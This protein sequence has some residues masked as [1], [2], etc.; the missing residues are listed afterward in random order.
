MES[1]E[2]VSRESQVKGMYVKNLLDRFRELGARRFVDLFCEGLAAQRIQLRMAPFVNYKEWMKVPGIINQGKDLE[3]TA[4]NLEGIYREWFEKIDTNPDNTMGAVDE[5][6]V[7]FFR[8]YGESIPETIWVYAIAA[9]L[10]RESELETRDEKPVAA[11]VARIM[12]PTNLAAMHRNEKGPGQRSVSRRTAAEEK[13]MALCQPGHEQ[14]FINVF[15]DALEKQPT[16]IVRDF[17]ELLCPEDWENLQGDQSEIGDD[18]DLDKMHATAAELEAEYKKELAKLQRDFLRKHGARI[19]H[20]VLP[21]TLAYEAMK[22]E[23]YNENFKQITPLL[24]S[25]GI[26]Y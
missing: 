23:G 25:M 3:E 5:M 2:G 17:E 14:S 10:F 8:E 26:D 4:E 6:Q 20:F 15:C 21:R 24:K 16:P 22:E 19:P 1:I 13:L 7:K 12:T 11:V 9:G 18:A